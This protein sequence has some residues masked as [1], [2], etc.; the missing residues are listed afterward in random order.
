VPYEVKLPELGP[1]IESIS[2]VEWYR[3]AGDSVKQGDAIAAIET[4]KATIELEAPADGTL[5]RILVAAGDE[6]LPQAA[7]ASAPAMSALSSR[8]LELNM[9]LP[10]D[11]LVGSG[12]QTRREGG[13]RREI[14]D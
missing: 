7:S 10:R 5:A 2:I 9:F 3:S 1:D 8:N 11:C 4:D 12:L 13:P 14:G 6:S